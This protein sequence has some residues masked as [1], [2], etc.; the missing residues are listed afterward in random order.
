[1]EKF[2]SYYAAYYIWRI[3]QANMT[4]QQA[5]AAIDTLVKE[6]KVFKNSLAY[7]SAM[8]AVQFPGQHTICGANIGTG[9][10]SSSKSWLGQTERILKLAGIPYA[11]NNIATKG[12]K[13]G[14]I[15]TANLE[16]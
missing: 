5:I 10:Y 8:E 1:V 15:I 7:K 9:K 16:G 2:G 6:K 11:A 13:V 14:D 3:K 4:T 12:G